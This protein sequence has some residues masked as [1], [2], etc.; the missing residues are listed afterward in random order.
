MGVTG[1]LEFAALILFAIN[2]LATVRNRR[3]LYSADAPLTPDT[4]VQD[5][6]NARP[7]VQ[8]RLRELGVTMFD[9][10][11][12]IAPSMT[13]GALALASGLKPDQLVAAL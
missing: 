7:Q 6:V 2:L 5:A 12:F 8:H 9:D 4:R 3:R 13:L 10:A 11:A 1:V